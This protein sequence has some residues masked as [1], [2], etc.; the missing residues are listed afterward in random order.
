MGCGI[1]RRDAISYTLAMTA[2]A[3]YPNRDDK[4]KAFLADPGY[5]DVS[6][7]ALDSVRRNH[8]DEIASIRKEIA[9]DLVLAHAGD[10]S[11]DQLAVRLVNVALQHTVGYLES[12]PAADPLISLR[13]A[14]R[15]QERSL[16]EL[17]QLSDPS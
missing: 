5:D 8:T 11:H 7:A 6:I 15:L 14:W 4:A 3:A 2:I 9:L 10:I 16:Q 13:R 1:N 17:L 12:N